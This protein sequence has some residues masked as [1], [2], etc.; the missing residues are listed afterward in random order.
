M[1]QRATVSK[2]NGR[3]SDIRKVLESSNV[4]NDMLLFSKKENDEIGEM[5][6]EDEEKFF[7]KET[8]T[9]ENGQ[10]TLYLK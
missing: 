3:L 6:R 5:K 4:I 10:D 8:I 7:L 1:E 9:N 2:A